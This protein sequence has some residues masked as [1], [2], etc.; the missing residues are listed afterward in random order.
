MVYSDH[1]T[2]QARYASA[3]VPCVSAS[4]S[5]LLDVQAVNGPVITHVA[6]LG[7]CLHD[8][9]AV[10]YG[11]EY[12][13]LKRDERVTR[14]RK[15]LEDQGWAY[16]WKASGEE[17]WF[18]AAFWQELPSSC[19][20]EDRLQGIEE[21]WVDHVTYSQPSI[22]PQFNDGREFEDT[23]REL[24]QGHPLYPPFP[25]LQVAKIGGGQSYISKDHR[26]LYCLKQLQE[27]SGRR[28]KTK[29]KVIADVQDERAF[30]MLC[31]L[32]LIHI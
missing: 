15:K 31:D 17:G 9:S 29:V 8:F 27:R 7:R 4:S 18:P 16:G 6:W 20:Q 23:I 5:F 19:Q 24:E 26:R 30:R 21:V 25:L 1:C 13:S 14:S 10:E 3:N 32:S 22:S 12:L 28:M 2:W 11:E